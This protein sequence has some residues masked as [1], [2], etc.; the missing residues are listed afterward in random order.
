MPHVV[1]QGDIDLSKVFAEY[2]QEVLSEQGLIIKL[3]DAF[4]NTDKNILL[5]ET[6]VV[7]SGPPNRFFIQIGTKGE[8]TTVRIYPG[9]DPEKTPGVK[10]SIAR[11]AGMICSVCEGVSCGATNIGDFL[12]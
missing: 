2:R 10:R 7:E 4:I 1:L 12:S 8:K 5:I 9:T 6:L 3:L 11:A